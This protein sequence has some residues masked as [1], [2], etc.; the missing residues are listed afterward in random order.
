MYMYNNQQHSE[1][2]SSN[3]NSMCSWNLNYFLSLKGQDD[4]LL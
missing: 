3:I 2:C 4:P 1:V